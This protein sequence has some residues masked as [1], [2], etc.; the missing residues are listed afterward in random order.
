MRNEYLEKRAS[1]EYGGFQW[2]TTMLE[3][4]QAKNELLK[5]AT[6]TAHQGKVCLASQLNPQL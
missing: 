3:A 1:G 5:R 2:P 6:L 4:R